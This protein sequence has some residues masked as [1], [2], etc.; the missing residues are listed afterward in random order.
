MMPNPY[1]RLKQQIPLQPQAQQ[2][3]PAAGAPQMQWAPMGQED[4]QGFGD[5]AGMLTQFLKKR[6]M[7]GDPTMGDAPNMT[8]P[9]AA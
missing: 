2:F 8:S 1:D 7:Q 3:N 9:N 6:R 4:T 5:V